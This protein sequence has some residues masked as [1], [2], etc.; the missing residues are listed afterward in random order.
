MSWNVKQ[1]G[2]FFFLF[3]YAFNASTAVRMYAAGVRGETRGLSRLESRSSTD[4][5]RVNPLFS[6]SCGES[7]APF[8]AG[9]VSGEDLVP[10]RNRRAL[11]PGFPFP[12]AP[13]PGSAPQ[14]F[15][16]ETRPFEQGRC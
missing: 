1:I 11:S 8:A 7:D 3:F 2:R 10:V 15:R 12:I 14:P 13:F 9:A 4:L 6:S 5:V 16:N